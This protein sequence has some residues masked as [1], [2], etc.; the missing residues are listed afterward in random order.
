MP[1]AF[2][3]CPAVLQT[4]KCLFASVLMLLIKACILSLE[5]STPNSLD[6]IRFLFVSEVIFRSGK[7]A[8]VNVLVLIH[9]DNESRKFLLSG[10]LYW[11]FWSLDELGRS[12]SRNEEES[13][14]K[15]PLFLNMTH[16]AYWSLHIYGFCFHLLTQCSDNPSDMIHLSWTWTQKVTAKEEIKDSYIV[17]LLYSLG[18]LFHFLFSIRLFKDESKCLFTYKNYIE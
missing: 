13:R 10:F 9:N 3:P 7:L 6:L 18:H 17:V 1:L 16:T 5:W 14:M 2:E 12:W 11:R 8:P 15:R 4:H